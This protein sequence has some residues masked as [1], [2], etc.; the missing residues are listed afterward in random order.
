MRLPEAFYLPTG[1]DRFTPTPATTSPWDDASQHG[2][3]P[4]ALAAYCVDAA[5]GRPDMRLG[6]LTVDFLGAIPR[7]P[8]DVA[9]RVVRP[10]R[11]IQLSEAT[12]SVDERPVVLARAWHLVTSPD[13]PPPPPAALAPP[14]PAAQPAQFFGGLTDWGFGEAIDWRFTDGDFRELGPAAVWTRLRIP[15]VAGVKLRGLD[16]A[17]VVADAA[18]GVSGEL[19]IER[20]LFV[21]TGLATTLAR[22]PAGEWVHLAARTHRS[23]DGVGVVHGVLSD[24]RGYL[25]DVSQPLLIAPR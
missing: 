18:N 7:R 13:A 21:P 9:I 24:D 20:F 25:G 15:L 5:I 4:S 2:G 16:R 17:L 23:D 1:P 22:H 19:P 8:M 10:G 3:P 6:R 14:L 11:R 12:L